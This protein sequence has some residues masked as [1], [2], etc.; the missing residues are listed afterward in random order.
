MV[1]LERNM[2][3]IRSGLRSRTASP[4]GP[5]SD[6]SGTTEESEYSVKV[7]PEYQADIP[8]LISEGPCPVNVKESALL[9]WSPS[10]KIDEETLD[11]YITDA[12][13]KF[14]YN[15][16][17]SLGMLLW[18]EY[19]L[20]KAR[21][22][23]QNYTPIPD[24]WS[25]EDKLL[26]EQG[27]QFHGK[28]F[29]RIRRMLPDK[30]LSS[31]IKYY[32]LWKKARPHTSVMDERVLKLS[33]P[34]DDESGSE[35]SSNNESDADSDKDNEKKKKGICAICNVSARLYCTARGSLCSACTLCSKRTGVLRSSGSINRSARFNHGH[36]KRKPPHG[37]Y[38]N[39]RDLVAMV[40]STNG[41][42][43]A[44]LH[45]MDC[46]ITSLKRQ[47]QNN[48]QIL[49][50]LN[51]KISEGID[52]HRP[53]E[54]EIRINN[55]WSNDEY[56]LAVQGIRRY[57]KNFKAIA[58]V[59]KTKNEGHVKNFFMNFRRRFNLDNLLKEYNSEYGTTEEIIEE[60]ME[61]E[62]IPSTGND[63]HPNSPECASQAVSPSL[64][65]PQSPSNESNASGQ[66]FLF[67]RPVQLEKL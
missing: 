18:H 67:N 21:A 11:K 37:M 53:P 48:K 27:F 55:R 42:K 25:N 20:K 52:V 36:I 24:E 19:D 39:S 57:G 60:K 28:N 29:N 2:L 10:S 49:S 41:E 45:N 22:D 38:L 54:G 9:M 50:Q 51:Q 33:A 61:K 58:E 66:N 44:I 46:E 12:K 62:P 47:V 31:V 5:Y 63:I 14:G 35:A 1:L 40:T 34:K 23:F 6:E 32:Y 3:D 26:F 13:E 59:I 65:L 7:G 64:H 17:Q 4:F 8:N 16:E 15:V 30:P 56:L 43:D